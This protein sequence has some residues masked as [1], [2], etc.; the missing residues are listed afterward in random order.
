MNGN[1][2]STLVAIPESQ[3]LF[4]TEHCYTYTVPSDTICIGELYIRLSK[5]DTE[6]VLEF[7]P[8]EPD[9]IPYE[10]CR[11]S[12]V[13]SFWDDQREDIYTFED[14]LPV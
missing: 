10:C 1:P 11:A 5:T 4:P 7:Q 13:L 6:C 2:S 3:N 14:G 12:G 8:P 9:I